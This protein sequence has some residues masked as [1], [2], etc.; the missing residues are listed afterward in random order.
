M[1]KKNAKKKRIF[2]NTNANKKREIIVQEHKNEYDNSQLDKPQYKKNFNIDEIMSFTE[3]IAKLVSEGVMTRGDEPVVNM[4]LVRDYAGEDVLDPDFLYEWAAI[5]LERKKYTEAELCLREIEKMDCWE[6]DETLEPGTYSF[7][8][9]CYFNMTVKDNQQYKD[10][11]YSKAKTCAERASNCILKNKG[12]ERNTKTGAWQVLFSIAVLTGNIL[13]ACDIRAKHNLYFLLYR[14]KLYDT[15]DNNWYVCNEID[16]LFIESEYIRL[17]KQ[18]IYSNPDSF[19]ELYQLHVDNPSAINFTEDLTFAATFIGN[20]ST[21]LAILYNDLF[22]NKN[23]DN[24]DFHEIFWLYCEKLSSLIYSKDTSEIKRTLNELEKLKSQKPKEYNKLE[25]PFIDE[26]NIVKLYALMELCEYEKVLEFANSIPNAE[27]NEQILYCISLTKGRLGDY[28]DAE[29]AALA[30]LAAEIDVFKVQNTGNL[31][32]MRQ[33]YYK[34]REMYEWALKII[35]VD[36]ID[37]GIIVVGPKYVPSLGR[38]A[39]I[40]LCEIYK[41]LIETYSMLNDFDK[42]KEAYEEFSKLPK[43]IDKDEVL[44]RLNHDRSVYESLK[45]SDAEKAKAQNELN[46]KNDEI[47]KMIELQKNWYTD[48]LRCQVTDPNKEITDEFWIDNDIDNKMNA[49]IENIKKSGSGFS[50]EKYKTALVKVNERFPRL[51]EQSRKCLATAEQMREVFEKNPML[52]AAPVLVEFGRVFEEAVW[53]YIDRTASY[54]TAAEK[55]LKDHSKTLGTAARIIKDNPG[56]LA[57][58]GDSIKDITDMR[59]D[60]AHAY[61]SKKHKVDAMWNFVWKKDRS[62]LDI[63]LG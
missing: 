46:T 13:E 16:G 9:S 41:K 57:K 21:R 54:K 38:P 14:T 51:S 4:K 30:S 47:R 48:L 12:L 27:I 49:V 50:E 29:R 32:Y 40:I 37:K 43:A 19:E 10:L 20:N 23:I 55:A 6:A 42:A 34:A 36:I 11:D 25:S 33:E 61:V 28:E 60:S 59:N 45:Q 56:P 52:D 15:W 17:L 63:L 3:D 22:S 35:K 2:S 18:E 8:A 31:Y 39:D 44:L 26:Y 1:A 58:H 62:L 53:K 5:Y 24:T 7:L